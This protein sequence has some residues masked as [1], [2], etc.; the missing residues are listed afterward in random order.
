MTRA[1]S[2]KIFSPHGL[3]GRTVSGESTR[4]SRTV[5]SKKPIRALSGRWTSR[6][7]CD[8]R[9]L[10]SGFVGLQGGGVHECHFYNLHF[11]MVERP[12]YGNIG[13]LGI[14]YYWVVFH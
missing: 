13:D 9:V 5:K 4:S 10:Q 14:V 6:W 8:A 1:T 3:R 2:V 12:P 11:E 7:V